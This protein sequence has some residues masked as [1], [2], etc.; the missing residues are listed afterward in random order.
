MLIVKKRIEKQVLNI[1]CKNNFSKNKYKKLDALQQIY[2]KEIAKVLSATY[3]F[4]H[5]CEK[6]SMLVYIPVCTW[7]YVWLYVCVCVC[8]FDS[9]K[10]VFLV[11]KYRTDAGFVFIKSRKR[12]TTSSKNNKQKVLHAL[13]H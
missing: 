12:K 1:N 9:I 11:Y 2:A 6:F 5:S 4:V 8:N 7:M 13:W 10:W 3:T